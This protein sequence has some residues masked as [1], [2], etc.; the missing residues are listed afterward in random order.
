[1]LEKIIAAIIIALVVGLVWYDKS[2]DSFSQKVPDPIENFI[3]KILIELNK[4][5]SASQ[6]AGQADQNTTQQNP[7]AGEALP[8]Q[9]LGQVPRQTTEYVPCQS[10]NECAQAYG[11]AAKCDSTVGTCYTGG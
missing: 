7:A 10:D 3:K 9:V 1:M 8:R 5:D 2:P 6:D 11:S 4:D